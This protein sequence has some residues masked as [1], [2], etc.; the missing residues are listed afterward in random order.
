MELINEGGLDMNELDQRVREVLT[1]KFKLGLFDHPLVD[2]TTL[3]DKKIHTQADEAISLQ[4]NRESIV[5]LKNEQQ[6][7]PID[8][9]KYKRILVTGPMAEATN[10]TTSR[11]GPSNNPIT[12]IKDGIIAYAKGKAV[13]V[14]YLKGVDVVDKNWPESEIIPTDLSKEEIESMTAGVRLG[15]SLI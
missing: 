10:Y 11:Y 7:L 9:G 4:V 12:T 15:M 14:N 3:A 13:Q 5:L 6:L 8:V 1:V 2:N